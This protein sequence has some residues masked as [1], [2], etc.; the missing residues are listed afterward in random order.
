[1]IWSILLMMVMFGLMVGSLYAAYILFNLGAGAATVIPCL[2]AIA[3]GI[4]IVHDLL[5]LKDKK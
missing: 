2:L 3:C 1:M 5:R 4:F